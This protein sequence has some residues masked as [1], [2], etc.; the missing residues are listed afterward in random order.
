MITSQTGTGKTLALICSL[1]AIPKIKDK[2]IIYT[3]RTENQLS[4]GLDDF[5]H[6]KYYKKKLK[7]AAII[8]SKNLCKCTCSNQ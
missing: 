8:G 1:L 6:T 2:R 4:H 5:K 7:S 3:S